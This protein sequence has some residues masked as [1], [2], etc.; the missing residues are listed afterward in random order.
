MDVWPLSTIPSTT[1]QIERQWKD[2]LGLDSLLLLLSVH[3]GS[4]E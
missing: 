2:P 3:D 4:I 1:I